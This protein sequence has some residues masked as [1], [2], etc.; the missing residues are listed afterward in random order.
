M[1][2]WS[3]YLGILIGQGKQKAETRKAVQK[4][5]QVAV[6]V[7]PLR[8]VRKDTNK[9]PLNICLLKT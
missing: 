9:D 2:K 6:G 7:I 5:G 1:I 4:F 3:C 8:Y